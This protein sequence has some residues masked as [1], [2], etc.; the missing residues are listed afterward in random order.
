LEL[1]EILNG[2][3]DP[4]NNLKPLLNTSGNQLMKEDTGRTCQLPLLTQPTFSQ[5]HPQKTLLPLRQMVS[6]LSELHLKD[7]LLQLIKLIFN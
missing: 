6:Q 4:L 2:L 1:I 5:T 3:K 7:Q